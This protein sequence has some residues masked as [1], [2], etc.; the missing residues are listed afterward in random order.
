MSDTEPPVDSVA[1]DESQE[2][3]YVCPDCGEVINPDEDGNHSI[4]DSSSNGQSGDSGEEQDG[5]GRGPTEDEDE[6]GTE[7]EADSGTTN[8]G[9]TNDPQSEGDEEGSES[10]E[11][12]E[13][14]PDVETPKDG[15]QTSSDGNN[16]GQ[17]VSKSPPEQP[18]ATQDA[19]DNGQEDS[20]VEL[21]EEQKE[22]ELEKLEQTSEERGA[23]EWYD[24]ESTETPDFVEN[25]F[26]DVED[27]RAEP[28]SEMAERRKEREERQEARIER[29]NHSRI[30]DEYNDRLATDV[31]DAFKQ[32]KTRERPQPSTHGQRV[33]V[34][35]VIRKQSGDPTEDRLYMHSEPSEAGDRCIT[36][37]VDGS[38]SMDEMEVKLA[39]KSLA[40]ACERIGD[41]FAA[42][43]YSTDG[44]FSPVEVETKLV[45]AP[46]EPFEDKHLDSFR[47]GGLTPTVSGIQDGRSVSELMPNKEEV[48]IVITDGIA[49]VTSDGTEH[50][51]SDYSNPA[52]KAAGKQVNTAQT[53][54]KRVI[55]LGVG[56]Q[57]ENE[58][59]S[60]IF[61]ESY[62]RADM[63][64]MADVLLEIYKDQMNTSTRRR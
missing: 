48:L 64:D 61:G 4:P 54:G 59:M 53:N 42:V 34:R 45:T 39:L 21:S 12:G 27:E 63:S 50:D 56:P 37:V 60:N 25:H 26:D 10:G 31:A 35:G 14:S 33:N 19:E 3:V 16:G 1:S 9:E 6:P 57:L 38:G 11:S 15:D 28:E 30:V 52:M 46:N 2:M 8:N 32:I 24:T 17:Q 13:E 47:V 51:N 44:T 62:V 58:A 18:N 55:G 23:N 43:S 29:V 7:Q 20:A 36:V 5:S 49:N 41:R 40:D 22:Q